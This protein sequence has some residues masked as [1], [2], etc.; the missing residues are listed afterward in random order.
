M[1]NYRS[2]VLL[3]ATAMFGYLF[4]V[5]GPRIAS[6]TVESATGSA[7][8]ELKPE[9]YMVASWAKG[10][11]LNV[12]AS[13]LYDVGKAVI[14]CVSQSNEDSWDGLTGYAPQGAY[15]PVVALD[16]PCLDCGVGE[17]NAR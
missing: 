13:A 14:T 7:P 9:N 2:V 15:I 12:L 6:A 4:L 16:P 1:K 5:S 3:A 10:L 8:V 11:G 17:Q